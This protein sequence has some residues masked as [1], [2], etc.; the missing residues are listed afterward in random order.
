M[1]HTHNVL[2]ALSAKVK[3]C[4]GHTGSHKKSL[5]VHVPNVAKCEIEC[6]SCPIG[7]AGL[8]VG[9]VSDCSL[10]RKMC[11]QSG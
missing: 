3:D 6:V 7:R 9:V 1:R 11:A 4:C 5:H 10:G 2:R 8:V